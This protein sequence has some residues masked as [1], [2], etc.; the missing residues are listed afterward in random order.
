MRL[1]VLGDEQAVLG[2]SLA[3]VGGQAAAT[4]D[5]V[6][7]GLRQVLDDPDIGILL[8]TADAAR[9]ARQEVDRLKLE[10]ALP[11]ILEIPDS[12][13]VTA[14][15]SIREFISQAIGVSL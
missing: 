10:A 2:F 3:G 12:E 7:A 14:E 9:M 4:P 5:E 15:F 1:F 8:I 11:L 6:Q 13:G